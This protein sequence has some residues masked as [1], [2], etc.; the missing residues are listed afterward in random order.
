MRRRLYRQ[1]EDSLD[2][3]SSKVTAESIQTPS[4]CTGKSLMV[5]PNRTTGGKDTFR[6]SCANN[7]ELCLFGLI[8]KEFVEHHFAISRRSPLKSEM[9]TLMSNGGS[10]KSSLVSPTYSERRSL[11]YNVNKTG[12]RMDPWATPTVS[13]RGRIG[14]CQS[15][16]LAC[17]MIDNS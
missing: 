1:L 15:W 6:V 2:I 17:V 16:P 5:F 11:K 8:I 12:R 10:A 14:H 3:W 4:L 7:K 9:A 13:G